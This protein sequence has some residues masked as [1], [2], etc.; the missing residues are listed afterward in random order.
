[1]TQPN[2]FLRHIRKLSHK[3]NLQ[4]SWLQHA[5]SLTHDTLNNKMQNYSYE[6]KSEMF[7]CIYTFSNSN[8]RES[9]PAGRVVTE[10]IIILKFIQG[11][12]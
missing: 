11:L 2:K 4:R 6:E 8:I 3:E 5:A 12:W 1:M 7:P 10:Q 9:P